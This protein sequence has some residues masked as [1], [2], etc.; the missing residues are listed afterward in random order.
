MEC[1]DNRLEL[2]SSVID[3]HFSPPSLAAYW[4][5]N[6]DQGQ[7]MTIQRKVK[8]KKGEKKVSKRYLWNTLGIRVFQLEGLSKVVPEIKDHYLLRS[9]RPIVFFNKAWWR[10]ETLHEEKEGSQR[11]FWLAWI[12]SFLARVLDFLLFLCRFFVCRS[13][14]SLPVLDMFFRAYNN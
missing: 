12:L 2:T 11:P 5:F 3:F 9:Q 6:K 13:R 14:N 7:W 10:H 8:N 1:R 4:L